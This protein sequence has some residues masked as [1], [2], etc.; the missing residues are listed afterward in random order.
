MDSVPSA[1]K[2][3]DLGALARTLE[4][5]T[6][7]YKFLFLGALLDSIRAEQFKCRTFALTRLGV[8]MMVRAWHP[9]KVFR[10][11]L[12]MRD[13]V[14]AAIDS[15]GLAQDELY[16]RAQLEDAFSSKSQRLDELLRYVPYRL[17]TPFFEG[18][19]RHMP[20]QK[21]NGEIRRLS[22]DCFESLRPLYRFLESDEIE[23]HPA[24]T[25]YLAA[26]FTFVA[27]WLERHWI[28]YLQARNPNV[29]AI[30]NKIA[31]PERRQTLA[32]QTRY[33]DTVLQGGGDSW[34]CVY[35]G[36]RLGPASFALDHFL[37][38]TFICHDA[39][40]N[41]IPADP[42]ANSA[43]RNRLPHPDY[44]PAFVRLQHRALCFARSTLTPKEWEWVSSSF[45]QDLRIVEPDLLDAKKLGEAYD[46]TVRPQLELARTIGFEPDWRWSGRL[47]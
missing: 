24:W 34:K 15:T 3:I 30:P 11:S 13:Q 47:G 7:S 4:A 26:N 42:Q 14:V 16:S 1:N 22:R 44:L 9:A 25:R 29:P 36:R 38:W 27:F 10:L 12:G 31:A 5:S 35:S 18:A 46:H 33:W 20:D 43:K 6:T 37:P 45:A 21:R 19:L 41:L 23:L 17:L 28:R 40:W 8:G 39:V 2:E 32:R